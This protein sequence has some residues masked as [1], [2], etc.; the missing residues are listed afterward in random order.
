V[1]FTELGVK[2][3]FEKMDRKRVPA[4]GMF[5]GDGSDDI[6]WMKTPPNFCTEIFPKISVYDFLHDN[7]LLF[8]FTPRIYY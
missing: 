8:Y 4:Q 5:L 3:G 1:S 6:Q 2:R 7:F